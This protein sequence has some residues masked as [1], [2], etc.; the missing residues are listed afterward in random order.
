MAKGD[1]YYLVDSKGFVV[2]KF[3]FTDDYMTGEC[4]EAC[5]WTGFDGKEP[6]DW[7]YVAEVYCKWDGCTHWW[8]RGEDYNEEIKDSDDAYYH[9]CG[10]HCFLSHIRAMCFV[11][12]LAAEYLVEN[13]DEDYLKEYT[14][15]SYFKDEKISNLVVFMLEGYEIRKEEKD[16]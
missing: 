14:T 7:N 6:V 16:K 8:F 3:E 4:Y 5:S 12:K 11:W 1:V 13:A 10:K 9:I 2:N 15:E